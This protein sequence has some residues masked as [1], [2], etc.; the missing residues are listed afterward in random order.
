MSF[1]SIPAELDKLKDE[2][3]RSLEIKLIRTDA[4]FKLSRLLDLDPKNIGA[5]HTALSAIDEL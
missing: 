5:Y 1:P 3:E 2:I 4:K